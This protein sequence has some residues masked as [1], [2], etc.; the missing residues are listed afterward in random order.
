VLVRT[1][2]HATLLAMLMLAGTIVYDAPRRV[3]WTL[4][5]LHLAYSFWLWV[6]MTPTPFAAAR[7]SLS[8][9]PLWAPLLAALAAGL[10]VLYLVARQQIAYSV[11]TRESAEARQPRTSALRLGLLAGC[12]AAGLAIA[13]T[14]AIAR[15]ASPASALDELTLS[16]V[17][18]PAA[19]FDG[20]TTDPDR[21]A[22]IAFANPMEVRFRWPR[23]LHEIRMH[24][25]DFDGRSYRFL[26]EGQIDNK[27]MP[28][29]DHSKEESRGRVVIPCPGASLWALR[30]TGL[31]NSDERINP[32]NKVL[33]LKELEFVP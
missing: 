17:A 11:D 16:G 22:T 19:L 5:T 4:M 2:S 32:T 18:Q 30:I 8:A 21:F 20:V 31:Y 6:W 15:H 3:R 25:W 29:L 14:L 7:L 1:S 9:R 13:A 28:L 10:G 26:V 12:A 24:L 27:W 23:R 33:H